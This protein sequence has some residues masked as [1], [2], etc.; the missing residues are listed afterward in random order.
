[1]EKLEK[2]TRIGDQIGEYLPGGPLSWYEARKG[3]EKNV[4]CIGGK[5]QHLGTKVVV[6]SRRD[7]KKK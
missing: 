1:V 2:R 6:S 7:Y 5:S 3:R 4:R